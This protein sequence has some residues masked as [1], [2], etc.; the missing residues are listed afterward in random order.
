MKGFFHANHREREDEF[1]LFGHFPLPLKNCIM[2]RLGRLHG[3]E[4]LMFEFF[5]YN[6]DSCNGLVWI[7]GL[8]FE[9][10]YPM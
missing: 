10:G 1:F 6:I 2:D 5:V 8:G 7:G 9:S 3:R 4:V